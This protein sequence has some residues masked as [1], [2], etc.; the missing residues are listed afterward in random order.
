MADIS[1][2]LQD[3]LDAVAFRRLLSHLGAHKE[4]QNI[5]LVI[6]LDFCLKGPDGGHGMAAEYSIQL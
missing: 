5:D 3:K 2:D 6:L 1:S 4:A